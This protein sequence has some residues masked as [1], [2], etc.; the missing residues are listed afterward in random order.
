MDADDK[1]IL[2]AALAV[3]IRYGMKRSTMAD[4]ARESGLSRQTLYD[5]FGDKDGIMAAAITY[6]N[7]GNIAALEDAIAKYPD[8]D[9]KI[10]A[11]FDVIVYATFDVM[12]TMPDAADLESG[13]GPASREASR[14]A[15]LEKREVLADMLR[16]Y[17]REGGPSAEEAA[18]FMEQATTRAKLSPITREELAQFLSVL[19]ASIL[20]MAQR[21]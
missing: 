21:G 12:Q 1:K 9:Q 11:F 2:D 13:M 4:V 20:A 8:L 7:S 18:A 17:F 16:P 10:T 6:G 15:A 3:V 5:R 14:L 19:K